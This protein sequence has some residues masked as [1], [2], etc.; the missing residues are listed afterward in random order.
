MPNGQKFGN[1]VITGSRPERGG[2]ILEVHHSNKVKV[3]RADLARAART[4]AEKVGGDPSL[5]DVTQTARGLHRS[6]HCTGSSRKGTQQTKSS[7]P[8]ALPTVR[9]L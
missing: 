1:V 3:E 2:V 9:A 7:G 8:G 5:I 4:L 6:G